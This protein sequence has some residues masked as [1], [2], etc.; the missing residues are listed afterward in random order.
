M[1]LTELIALLIVGLIA[2]AIA[3]IIMKGKS[4]GLVINVI[5]G[6]IGSYI[7]GWIFDLLDIKAGN[8]IVGSIIT[9]LI[10][11]M[12]LLFVLNRLKK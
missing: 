5:V 8:G 11:A 4:F 7:G 6:V 9:A 12:A 10:G 3:G 2:G 1:E